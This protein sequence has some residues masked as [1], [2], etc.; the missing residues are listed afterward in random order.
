MNFYNEYQLY[1][2]QTHIISL[3]LMLYV[4]FFFYKYRFKNLIWEISLSFVV[5]PL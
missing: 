2:F 5:C 1:A 3:N 4:L